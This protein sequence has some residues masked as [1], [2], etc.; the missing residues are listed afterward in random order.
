MPAPKKTDLLAV[1]EQ[2]T[3]NIRVGGKCSFGE[4]LLQETAENRETLLNALGKYP[5]TAIAAALKKTGRDVK[6]NAINRHRRG[7]C[8]CP[9]E[10][11]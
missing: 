6:A 10:L 9:D 4:V 2:E 3:A 11:R 1:I 7:V 5:G 8:S